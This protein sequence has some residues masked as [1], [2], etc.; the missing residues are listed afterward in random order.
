MLADGDPGVVLRTKGPRAVEDASLL[1]VDASR[2][3]LNTPGSLA[4]LD[5]TLLAVYTSRVILILG[6]TE[7]VLDTGSVAVLNWAGVDA[8]LEIAT[9]ETVPSEEESKESQ[10]DFHVEMSSVN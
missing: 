3:V 5:P 4:V 6:S 2:V 7:A 8:E 1:V 10:D 9:S